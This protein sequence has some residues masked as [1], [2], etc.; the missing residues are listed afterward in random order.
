LSQEEVLAWTQQHIH[1]S[2][3]VLKQLRILPVT[4]HTPTEGL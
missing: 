3:Q 2:Q 4:R 1:V